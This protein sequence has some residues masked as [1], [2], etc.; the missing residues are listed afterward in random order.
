MLM[1]SLHPWHCWQLR[2]KKG[3]APCSSRSDT[4]V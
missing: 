3:H 2:G 1:K 4:V